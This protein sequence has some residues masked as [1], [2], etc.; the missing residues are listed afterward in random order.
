MFSFTKVYYKY[1]FFLTNSINEQGVTM[2][3]GPHDCVA[4]TCHSPAIWVFCV[5]QVSSWFYEVIT[6]NQSLYL[7]SVNP[8]YDLIYN[9]LYKTCATYTL[10]YN[11]LYLDLEI[12]SIWG[13]RDKL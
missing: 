5:Q 2:V 7:K 11:N 4:W 6:L 10:F 12:N 8:S 3:N 1:S 9:V 13:N